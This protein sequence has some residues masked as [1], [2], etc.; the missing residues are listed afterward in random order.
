MQG[1][2]LELGKT[3]S[4]NAVGTALARLWTLDGRH[5]VCH[6]EGTERSLECPITQL[7]PAEP[8]LLS[9]GNIYEKNAI[10]EWLHRCG[11]S[12]CTN[13]D[14][15]H[16]RML[17]LEE[18]RQVVEQFLKSSDL[19]N[20][21]CLAVALDMRSQDACPSEASSS[22]PTRSLQLQ[23]QRLEKE[24]SDYKK[25]MQRL[26]EM[27]SSTRDALDRSVA[28][29]ALREEAA[30][31]VLQ[32]RVRRFLSL[33]RRQYRESALLLQAKART[34]SSRQFLMQLWK[35]RIE[36]VSRIARWWRRESLVIKKARAREMLDHQLTKLR[37]DATAVKQTK[38][39]PKRPEIF[40]ASPFLNLTTKSTLLKACQERE[41]AK[42][43]VRMR[44][45]APPIEKIDID[46]VVQSAGCSRREANLMLGRF[47]NSIID[48][49]IHCIR[50]QTGQTKPGAWNV[51]ITA[52]Q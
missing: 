16:G 36:A 44:G 4:P 40:G 15:E 43:L 21:P 12:P 37:R 25:Y 28:E 23:V 19:A 51:E 38:P 22:M 7:P 50:K 1:R 45:R 18:Y 24:M 26:E 41:V 9:D 34:F 5:L 11:R 14:L 17:Q 32:G 30:A 39:E 35:P 6:A 52:W 2:V 29:L 47:S 3:C 13:L 49:T 20:N 46:L 10:L 33:R 42:H 31:K 8:V 48:A 27:C